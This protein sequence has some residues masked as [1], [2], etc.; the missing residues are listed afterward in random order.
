M[1]IGYKIRYIY[2][3]VNLDIIHTS[4]I[5]YETYPLSYTFKGVIDT[6]INQSYAGLYICRI[7]GGG[8]LFFFK[9]GGK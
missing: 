4:T 3:Y 9:W 2:K 7:T 8:G 1:Q 5:T 6:L